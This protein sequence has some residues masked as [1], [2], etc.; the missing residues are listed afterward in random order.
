MNEKGLSVICYRSVPFFQC[1]L[2]HL[3]GRE[4][5]ARK[6]K[7]IEANLF[8]VIKCSICLL[9]MTGGEQGWQGTHGLYYLEFKLKC[10]Q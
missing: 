8:I 4:F 3:E 2:S 6:P 7:P 9:I 10:A 1:Y 5:L